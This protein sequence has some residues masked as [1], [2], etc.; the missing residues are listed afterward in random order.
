MEGAH[1]AAT[2]KL[3]SFSEQWLVSC[4]KRNDGCDGGLQDL[5]FKYAEKNEAVLESDWK[6]TGR[7]GTCKYDDKPHTKV[8]VTD[9]KT[10]KPNSP[11]QMKAALA[12]TTLAVSVDAVGPKFMNYESGIFDHVPLIT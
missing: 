12:T 7:D 2:G 10:V 9:Y 11:A 4:S 6:Y 1:F 8:L 5:A 3:L